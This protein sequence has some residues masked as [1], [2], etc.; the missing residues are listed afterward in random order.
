MAFDD[1]TYC[2]MCGRMIRFLWTKTGKRM[3]CD[4]FSVALRP[5]RE[6][7][8]YYEGDQKPIYGRKCDPEEPGAVKAWEPHYYTCPKQIPKRA[9]QSK[10]DSE[11]A[12]MKAQQHS[13]AEKA[14][15]DKLAAQLENQDWER[16]QT[17]MFRR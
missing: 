10:A 12:A 1:V 14:K 2:R 15:A 9:Y 11:A 4:S 6:G 13:A 7:R 5:D 3:P 17:S 8:L 16:R